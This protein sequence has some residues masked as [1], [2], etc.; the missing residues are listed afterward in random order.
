MSHRSRPQPNFIQWL[1]N[2][3][4]LPQYKT[5]LI[6]NGY[7]TIEF[8]LHIKTQQQLS[9][10]GIT[11]PGHQLQLLHAIQ[12]LRTTQPR[13]TSYPPL[14]I[15]EHQSLCPPTS[16]EF[17]QP[18][19]MS[20]INNNSNTNTLFPAIIINANHFTPSPIFPTSLCANISPSN[21]SPTTT[22][23]DASISCSYSP[24]N[25][26]FN[27]HSHLIVHNNTIQPNR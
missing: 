21:I 10:I 20:N 8:V 18:I 2:V 7:N 4:K 23:F 26:N 22:P 19:S 1:T 16:S 3:V 25:P 15:F 14:N 27:N 24:T 5:N 12:N 6:S 13:F 11:K 9:Q 17:T